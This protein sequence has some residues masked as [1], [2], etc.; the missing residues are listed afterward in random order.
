MGS[1]LMESFVCL[2]P[3]FSSLMTS[4]KAPCPNFIFLI[5]LE[6]F[7]TFN[8]NSDLDKFIFFREVL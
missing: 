6:I 3:L 2:S 8:S 5:S 7:S 1:S 4:S